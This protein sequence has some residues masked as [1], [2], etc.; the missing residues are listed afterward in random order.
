MVPGAFLP[1]V[2]AQLATAPWPSPD[3]VELILALPGGEE[4]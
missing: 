3:P 1:P 4:S 2:S